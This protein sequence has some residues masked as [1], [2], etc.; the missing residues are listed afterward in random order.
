MEKINDMFA[1]G[2]S[3]AKVPLSARELLTEEETDRSVD[4]EQVIERAKELGADGDYLHRRDRQDC[5]H[6]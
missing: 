1:V 5:Q 4:K 2:V 3:A 6:P